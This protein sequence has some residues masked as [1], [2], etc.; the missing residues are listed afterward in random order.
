MVSLIFIP[1]DSP[2]FLIYSIFSP[3]EDQRVVASKDWPS[4]SIAMVPVSGSGAQP[5]KHDQTDEVEASHLPGRLLVRKEREV[6]HFRARAPKTA[7]LAWLFPLNGSNWEMVELEG[8]SGFPE[9]R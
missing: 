9:N 6:D 1:K 8:F 2:N 4:R 3:N 5:Q 7:A